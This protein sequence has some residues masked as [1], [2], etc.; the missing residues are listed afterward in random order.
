M[1]QNDL[2]VNTLPAPTWNRLKLNNAL[3][4]G[5]PAA[6][7]LLE[8]ETDLEGNVHLYKLSSPCSCGCEGD[9]DF[10]SIPT[11]MGPELARLGTP[12][13]LCIV[14]DAGKASAALTFRYS[15]GLNAYSKIEIEACEDAELTV[16][17]TYLAPEAAS[18][19]SAVETKILAGTNAK[20]KL[21]QVQML[22]RSFTHL[23][24]VGAS[25][26][27]H[28][29]LET[30]QLE[31]GA[32]A[33]YNGVRSELLGAGSA[34]DAAIAYYGRRRQHLDLNFIANHYGKNTS[35][36]MTADGVLKDGASKIYRGTI[37]FKF[38]SSGA[39]GTED[40]SVL[41]LSDDVVNQSVPLILCSEED[42]QG[43]H[44]ASIGKLD[45]D[46]LF[47]LM[48]RGF[49]EAEATAML[50]KAKIDSLCRRIEAEPI[51]AMVE[52]Y[53]EEVIANGE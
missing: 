42:V 8:P 46:L 13:T 33:I 11:G 23:N 38:G 20:V 27:D 4:R 45:E 1:Q 6:E 41:L 26:G 39:V 9:P 3:V 10:A 15:D 44:G 19:M 34:F 52:N 5:L 47:Y 31:L 40:E 2:T 24:N 49:T 53:L 43:N 36:V 18:G 37:D 28:A 21:V 29:A 35:C 25:L 16:F 7:G 48:S 12:S 32:K 14:A 50:A 17:M 51:V 22:G 30:V